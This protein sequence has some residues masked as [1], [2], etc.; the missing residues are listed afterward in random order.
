MMGEGIGAGVEG[1]AGD[2]GG[3]DE[4]ERGE[5]AVDS[6]GSHIEEGLAFGKD[7]TRE[8]DADGEDGGVGAEGELGGAAAEGVEAAGLGGAGA[9]GEDEEVMAFGEEGRG[10]VEEGGIV[11]KEE[12]GDDEAEE[13]VAAEAVAGE[14]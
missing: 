11:W 10:D 14:G 5:T 3:V 13:G 12:A 1:G 9:F 2:V 8:G 6:F 7:A 4:G